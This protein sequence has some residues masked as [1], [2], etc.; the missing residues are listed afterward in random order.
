M[1]ATG[2]KSS[3]ASAG[4]AFT[5]ATAA[6]AA[7]IGNTWWAAGHALFLVEALLYT[8][9]PSLTVFYRLALLGLVASYAT[10]VYRVYAASASVRK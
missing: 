8:F 7:A 10:D 5:G 3:S 6:Q 4:T 2:D 1:T 9:F